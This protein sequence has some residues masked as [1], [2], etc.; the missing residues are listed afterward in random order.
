MCFRHEYEFPSSNAVYSVPF[1]SVAATWA[2]PSGC[3]QTVKQSGSSVSKSRPI[4]RGEFS[5]KVRAQ[6]HC[7]V[8]YN[9]PKESY[10]LFVRFFG[11]MY[12]LMSLL[13]IF[14]KS[15]RRLCAIGSRAMDENSEQE[16]AR[17]KKNTSSSVLLLH[18]GIHVV[19][20]IRIRLVISDG[21][22]RDGN[23]PVEADCS[24]APSWPPFIGH[25]L[26]NCLH[27]SSVMHRRLW[28]KMTLASISKVT[29]VFRFVHRTSYDWTEI[30]R[31]PVG[32]WMVIVQIA[33]S[34]HFGLRVEIVIDIAILAFWGHG[35]QFCYYFSTGTYTFR[36]ISKIIVF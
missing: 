14:C 18:I 17:R 30:F 34:Y 8:A 33:C 25:I 35:L 32:R 1:F 5:V 16:R 19:I 22:H 24:K 10:R 15:V 29:L 4:R 7:F 28:G 23:V 12:L 36:N 20:P 21:W 2:K 11:T 31:L 6:F 27:W 9:C 26:F 3:R 13:Q